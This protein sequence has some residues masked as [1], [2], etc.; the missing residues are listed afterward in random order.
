MRCW[1]GYLSAARCKQ[2]SRGPADATAPIIS[3]F[4]KIQNNSQFH[5]QLTRV[6]LEKTNKQVF[7]VLHVTPDLP[8]AK[9]WDL[10]S[11]FLEAKC[12]IVI[13]QTVQSTEKIQLHHT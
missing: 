7:V 5:C 4:S 9:H 6:V 13:Q 2:F 12:L 8:R 10:Q 1:H 3:C 11:R